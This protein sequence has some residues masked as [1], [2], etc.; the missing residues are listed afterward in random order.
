MTRGEYMTV[1]SRML[2]GKTYEVTD[3]EK[4]TVPFYLHHMKHLVEMKI[5]NREDPESLLQRYMVFYTLYRIYVT[6]H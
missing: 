4:D 2:Y 6:T 5:F 3:A 1:L